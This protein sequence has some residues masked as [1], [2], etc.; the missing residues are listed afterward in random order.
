MMGYLVTYPNGSTTPRNQPFLTLL[1]AKA[2]VR[3]A[4]GGTIRKYLRDV[5]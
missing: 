5:R 4:G 3:R 1:E 2:E